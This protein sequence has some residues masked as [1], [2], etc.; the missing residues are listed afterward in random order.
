METRAN[1]FP[2]GSFLTHLFARWQEAGYWYCILRE[3]V[4]LPETTDG[5]DID[6][7]VDSPDLEPMFRMATA[8]AAQHGGRLI[9]CY[10][11]SGIIARFAGYSGRW[12]GVA[13]D[14]FADFSYRGLPYYSTTELFAHVRLWRTLPVAAPTDALI[15]GFI[16][17]CLHNGRDRKDYLAQASREFGLDAFRQ[18]AIFADCF[19]IA[20]AQLLVRLFQEG[21]A[22]NE[23]MGDF[24]ACLWNHLWRQ[25]LRKNPG[26]FVKR[27]LINLFNRLRRIFSPP[28]FMLVVLGTDGSGKTAIIEFLRHTLDPALHG[29]IRV[30]HWRPGYLP[31]IVELLGGKG[32]DGPV[33]NPHQAPS[34]GWFG[35]VLRMGYYSLDFVLGYWLLVFPELVRK[36]C[37]TIFDRYFYDFYIDPWRS[38][39]DL[40]LWVVRLADFFIPKPHLI[41]CLGTD[42]DI[43]F[44]RKPE[45]CLEEITLQVEKLRRFN[46]NCP[47]SFWIDT[48]KSLG[49][50]QDDALAALTRAMSIRL[51]YQFGVDKVD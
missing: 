24:S 48:G 5:H 18:Q 36:P 32:P 22:A 23:T 14:F 41:L 33:K 38:R 17:E 51:E 13:I 40:P 29:A 1:S 21:L 26:L 28:G 4:T 44:A 7:L 2:E 42:P 34:S 20:G 10:R 6:L 19:G 15:S 27:R 45:L 49:E 43:I 39:V 16:K 46:Q 11:Q 8:V 50:T 9:A 3:C 37:L 31:S 35:S 47:R 12:W 30:R 25:Q